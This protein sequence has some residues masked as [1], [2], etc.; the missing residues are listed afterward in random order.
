MAP[1]YDPAPRLQPGLDDLAWNIAASLDGGVPILAILEL[2]LRPGVDLWD[3]GS[4]AHRLLRKATEYIASIPATRVFSARIVGEDGKILLLVQ[5]PNARAW[6]D[7]QRSAALEL[8]HAT[9]EAN[10]SNRCVS[11]QLPDSFDAGGKIELLTI[12]HGPRAE[13]YSSSDRDAFVKV[14]SEFT[15]AVEAGSAADVIGS[16]LEADCMTSLFLDQPAGRRASILKAWDEQL[17]YFVGLV[18][19]KSSTTS[20]GESDGL[21]AIVSQLSGLLGDR[22]SSRILDVKPWS[23][24]SNDEYQSDGLSCPTTTEMV[25]KSAMRPI[26]RRESGISIFGYDSVFVDSYNAVQTGERQYPVPQG[27]Y[28][29]VGNM[30]Q[31]SCPSVV[32]VE[33]EPLDTKFPVDVLWLQFRSGALFGTEDHPSE[34]RT[35]FK[36]IRKQI[37]QNEHC[38]DVKWARRID[39]KDA[40]ALIIGMHPH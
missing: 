1:T 8:L 40:V 12:A 9:L 2:P 38:K 31:H 16:W 14:W 19:H 32:K 26:Y 37:W 6:Q 15:T 29:P 27:R 21:H 11:L 18:V 28:N 23:S 35:R 34:G 30:N 39:N 20:P 10:P 22:L 25:L 13:F 4:S 5:L 33:D 7:L 17:V 24:V 3:A 36:R